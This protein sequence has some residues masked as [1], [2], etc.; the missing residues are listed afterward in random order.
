MDRGLSKAILTLQKE[1]ALL[2]DKIAELEGES[3]ALQAYI[4]GI[5]ALYSATKSIASQDNLF[6]LLDEILYQALV[7]INAVHGS[8]L[9]VD[10]ET[11]ELV[12]VVVHGEF[13][14]DLQGHRI[15]WHQGIAGAVLEYGDPIIANQT[16][17]DPRFSAEIDK[18]IGLTSRRI[19]AVPLAYS[20]KV[21]GVIELV[22][23][24]D[25]SD[26]TEFD[27]TILSLLAVFAA[28]S[29]EQIEL[30]MELKGE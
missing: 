29:L 21:L 25:N 13:R 22:N 2:K 11:K 12:F 23:K 19:L 10:E 28:T 6:K 4:A 18:M 26:F 3:D 14:G 20:N 24:H 17:F 7:V 30:Q 1:N 16:S 5:S 15:D 9:L 8:L 27:A